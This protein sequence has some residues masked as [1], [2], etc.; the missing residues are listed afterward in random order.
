MEFTWKKTALILGVFVLLIGGPLFLISNPMMD[1]Y[2][3][4]CEKEP[5]SGFN[6]WLLLNICGG[7]NYKTMRAERSEVAYR[8]YMEFYPTDTENRPLALLRYAQSLD[9]Q[10]KNQAALEIYE[11]FLEEFPSHPEAN[12]AELGIKN[13]KYVKPK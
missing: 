5:A 12:T 2:Q 13:I 3:E 10:N 11:Q 4:R 6:Q 8:K 9:D 1:Y 7:M